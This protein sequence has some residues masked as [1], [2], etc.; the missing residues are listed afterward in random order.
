[1]TPPVPDPAPGDL[2]DDIRELTGL[3]L[4]TRRADLARLDAALAAG[5]LAVIR[6]VG[7]AF[8]GSSAPFGFVEAGRL[9][10]EPEEAAVRRPRA[11]ARSFPSSRRR[12]PRRAAPM[13]DAAAPIAAIGFI[14][15]FLLALLPLAAS[16]LGI[17]FVMLR[18]RQGALAI[19]NA[20]L[21]H[22]R[23]RVHFALEGAS[24]TIWDWDIATG[25][26]WLNA[27]WKEMLGERPPDP[28][29]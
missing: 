7:H 10:A 11:V 19:A 15:A 4:S 6:A 22:E 12:C 14:D 20:A 23:E 9:G 8:K 3:Y 29:R 25:A 28:T 21:A 13:A 16:L 5:D 17:A 24:L 27:N 26:V 1:M 2:S 18:R